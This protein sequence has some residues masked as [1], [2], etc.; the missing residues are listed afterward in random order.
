M[1]RRFFVWKK[2]RAN[3]SKLGIK[4]WRASTCK[5]PKTLIIDNKPVSLYLQRDYSTRTAFLNIFLDD[6]YGL[7]YFRK[8]FNEVRKIIDVGANQG[9]FTLYAKTIFPEAQIASYEP[10]LMLYDYLQNQSYIA[11][12][13][14][15]M[16]AVGLVNGNVM[17]NEGVDSL[18]STTRLNNNGNIRQASIKECISRMG[19]NIDL[20]K[21]DCE[22]AEWEILKD[23]DALKTVRGITM[24]YHIHGSIL[25]RTILE[26]LRDANFKVI[27]H[28]VDGPTWGVVWAINKNINCN[29]R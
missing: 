14:V 18:H 4:F 11:G 9:L 5:T 17:L 23:V 28:S 3:S 25:H 1:I 22:G 6:C 20:L 7:N 24:E 27:Y 15:Y 21:L 19:G 2:R 13:K 8:N 26:I 12:A 16:E 10:N 29:T